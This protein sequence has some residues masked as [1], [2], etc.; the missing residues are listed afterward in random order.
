MR[1]RYSRRAGIMIGCGFLIA[2]AGS[3]LGCGGA[4][5]IAAEHRTDASLS[6]DEP[7]GVLFKPGRPVAGESLEEAL[8]EPQAFYLDVL[9]RNTRILANYDK[10]VFRVVGNTD[11]RECAGEACR[12]LSLRRSTIVD[13]WLR[14]HGVPAHAL[15]PPI[16]FG[17]DRP[18]ADNDSEDGR[19]NNRN[20]FLELEKIV[21]D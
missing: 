4:R 2:V 5:T 12:A 8:A 21:S 16:G 10:A 18:R 3:L 6:A 9:Q 7:L 15:A 11:D 14:A 1:F 17:A 20:A 19:S 13:Q